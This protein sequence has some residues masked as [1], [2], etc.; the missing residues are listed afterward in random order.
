LNTI[1]KQRWLLILIAVLF[2]LPFLAAVTMRF[3]GW[4]PPRT[5]NHG[6]L[7]QPPLSMDGVQ[8]ERDNGAEWVFEN[9]DR[10]WSLL[11]RIPVDCETDC[12]ERL[13]LLTRV[14]EALGR[15]APKLTMFALEPTPDELPQP[16]RRL[17]IAGELPAPLRSPVPE[18]MPDVW[19]VD[20][21]G[22]LVMHYP[23]A[24]EPSG[25]RRDLARLVR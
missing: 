13:E 15:H 12:R 1:H 9:R 16:L 21:H 6:E 24:F 11:A 23:P 7:L 18:A 2:L 22:Y 10:E 3:G 19:L 20:P 5:R 17:R 8:A 14:H 4:E 25:L